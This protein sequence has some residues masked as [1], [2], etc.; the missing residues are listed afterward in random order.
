VRF[1]I[2]ECLSPALVDEAR[3]AGFEAYHLVHIGGVA[4]ADWRIAAY[5]IARD[6]VLVTNN[7]TDFQALYK[8]QEVQPGLV[9]IVPSVAASSRFGCFELHSIGLRTCSTSSTRS[10]K[11]TSK[12]AAGDSSC[13]ILR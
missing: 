2:D 11:F 6:S 9:V 13:T 1:L 3:R 7:R 12:R 8:R 10:W 5:A 4:W